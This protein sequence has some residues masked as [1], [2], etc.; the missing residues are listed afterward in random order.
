VPMKFATE[1]SHRPY[2][3]RAVRGALAI[4]ARFLLAKS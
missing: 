2:P 3:F 4:S 1:A